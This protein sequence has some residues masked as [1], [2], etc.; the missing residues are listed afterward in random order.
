MMRRDP[1][2]PTPPAIWFPPPVAWGCPNNNS[3]M[4]SICAAASG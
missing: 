4:G 2:K 3:F 1:E